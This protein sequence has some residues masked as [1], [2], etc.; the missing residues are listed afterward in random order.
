MMHKSV[1]LQGFFKFLLVT[2][3]Y[4]VDAVGTGYVNQSNIPH[5]LLVFSLTWLYRQTLFIH[6][7]HVPRSLHVAQYI[8]LQFWYR[9]Q[10]VGHVLILLDITYNLGCLGS[11]G[12]VDQRRLFNNGWNTI[13]DECEVSEVNACCC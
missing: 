10:G 9:L 3:Y 12:E 11:L 7:M 6:L 2:S 1:G 8:L 4:R 5:D 13:F